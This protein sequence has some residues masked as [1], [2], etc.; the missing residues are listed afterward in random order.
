[1]QSLKGV[2]V[3]I[4]PLNFI[5][6]LENR[7]NCEIVTQ[8]LPP[9]IDAVRVCPNGINKSMY[10]CVMTA[11][12]RFMDDEKLRDCAMDVL[13]QIQFVP[14][15]VNIVNE[16]VDVV[17]LYYFFVF[18][19]VH[20]NIFAVV[21]KCITCYRRTGTISSDECVGRWKIN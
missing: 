18:V 3:C 10:V 11:I 16:C 5:P 21:G 4:F 8:Q 2:R 19:Y 7:L 1:M 14:N 17:C 15:L 12:Q 13:L 9:I 6:N 20:L